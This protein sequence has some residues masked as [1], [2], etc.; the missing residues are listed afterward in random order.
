MEENGDDL[1]E[2]GDRYE[3]GDK[4][5]TGDKHDGVDELVANGKGNVQERPKSVPRGVH[6]SDAGSYKADARGLFK[7][8]ESELR[9]PM[10]QVNDDYCDCPDSSDE[11]GTSACPH[12]RFFCTVQIP[13]RDVQFVYSSH[14]NDGICDCC[15][16]SDEWQDKRVPSNMKLDGKTG[17]V[18]HTPCIDRC[19]DVM[20]ILEDEQ[21]IRRQGL[22]RQK[23]YLVAARNLTLFQRQKYGPAG[24]FYLLSQQCYEHKAHEY[25]YT[26]CPF[27]S[28]R[29]QGTGGFGAKT[30]LGRHGE[31]TKQKSGDYVH[32]MRNGDATLCPDGQ[33]RQT[34][35]RFLCGLEDGIID[36][37]EAS[38][39]RYDVRF[40]SPAAC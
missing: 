18:F 30:M 37:T 8:L 17:A 15:D 4:S 6:F 11:P 25:V 3:D 36:V 38:K 1:D 16:G 23:R 32:S 27:E 21:R 20:K 10:N 31:W 34:Q 2:T 39:C 29:Q 35:L 12:A 13:H 19:G 26:V 33:P 14:V 22:L 7:C 5:E 40:S 24:I 28:V 9:I